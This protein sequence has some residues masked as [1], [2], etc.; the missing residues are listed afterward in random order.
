M[1]RTY[2]LVKLRVET[3]QDLKRLMAQTGQGSLDDL[4]SAMTRLMDAHRLG[5]KETGWYVH[6]KR[7]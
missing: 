3:V 1:K 6:S 5:L 2:Q 4:V 7:G